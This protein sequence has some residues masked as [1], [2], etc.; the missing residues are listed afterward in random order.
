MKRQINKSSNS[1]ASADYS[2]VR[3]KQK[4]FL[5]HDE[6]ELQREIH[7]GLLEVMDPGFVIKE[8]ELSPESI[9]DFFVYDGIGI[10]L[11]IKGSKRQIYRQCERYCQF[12]VI[13]SLILITN[14]SMG[15]PEQINGKDCYVLKLGRAWL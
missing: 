3:L 4:R 14:L 7:S 1:M 12:D 8:L 10:E 2:A 13:K 11:K 15:F 9:I 5:L 6:K